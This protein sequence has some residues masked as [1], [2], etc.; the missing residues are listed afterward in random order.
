[1]A[2][3]DRDIHERIYDEITE[4]IETLQSGALSPHEDGTAWSQI[5]IDQALSKLHTDR[6]TLRQHW[7]AHGVVAWRG[8]GRA[9]ACGKEQPCPH[10]I[11]LGEEYVPEWL[12]NPNSQ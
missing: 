4:R 6:E 7:A 3:G 5:D 10:T 2:L 9:K 11:G 12:A 1:M 8:P